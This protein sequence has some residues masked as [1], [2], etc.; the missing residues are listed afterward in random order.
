MTRTCVT[1]VVACLVAAGLVPLAF[2][3]EG[4]WLFNNPPKEILKTRYG[5]D[6]TDSWLEHV[7][8]S[9]VRFNSGGSG[10]FVSADG[11]V[12]TNHHV[13]LETLQKLSTK[14]KNY[15]K[16]GF[17]A[18]T[19]ADEA[20]AVDLEL[21]VLME[22]VDVTERVKAEV[23]PGMSPEEAFKARR[24][25]T[26]I[27]EK[28]SLDKT[29]L[30]SNVISLYQGGRY[31]LYRFK[32]YTDVRLVFAPEQQIAFFGGDPDNFEYPRYNLDVCLFRVY[33][34]DQ[35]LKP[36]HF[37][38]WSKAGA[39]DGELVFVAGHPGRTERLDTMAE[40]EFLRDTGY[41]FTMRRLHRREVMLSVWSARS[42]ENARRAKDELFSIQNARKRYDGALAGLLD[43]VLMDQKREAEKTFRQEIAK[44]EELKE[45]MKA[46]DK[47]AAVQQVRAKHMLEHTALEG[48]AGFGTILFSIARTLVRA[49]A[50]RPK[51][52]HERLEEFT[53]SEKASME[54]RLFSKRPIHDD[55]EQAK[56]ADSL[57]WL[58]EL[59][60]YDHPSVKKAL[61]GKS[62]RA[63]ASELIR[64]TK[65]KDVELRRSLY[66]GGT[67]AIEASDD[68]LIK[69][70]RDVD[71]ESRALRK[72][73]DE[74][75]KELKQQAYDQIA[76]AKFA[77]EGT[78]TYPDATF[79]LRLAFGVCKGYEEDGRQIPCATTYAGLY[80]RAA[81]QKYTPPFDLP[82]RWL[83]RKKDL[84]LAAPFNFVC[85]NDIIGGNSGSPVVNRD[86]EVVGLIFDG[87]IQ[88]LVLDFVFT[89]VQ[90]RALAVHSRGIV[91][92]LRKVCDA[93]HI[94]Q[95]LTGEK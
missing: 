95:E 83:D 59:L 47:I 91:E 41:P 36:E 51:V 13:G 53:E 70:A 64:G 84:D 3:D 26:S 61:A 76:K 2:A 69:L 45:A 58:A 48:G 57:T 88:S 79:T 60:G 54:L 9:A 10:S 34:K 15:V 40:L 20:K 6:A 16:E 68:P 11:L 39:K 31:H 80:D 73:F 1:A 27:I 14:D 5:F 32:R 43:P 28:E 42:L 72:I 92:A 22:I 52:N 65:L 49:A 8:K 93:S 35:P 17:L 78:S 25:I 94:A 46:F 74:Q 89:E 18:R 86:A 55:L 62:P 38:K 37:L 66:D 77:I 56:L 87:N 19:R 30:R 75:V 21:N 12:M 24:A 81:E 85:T 90:S 63:R 33:E 4:M 71:P 7:Q 82:Q 67:K 44:R 23:K 50:E 29:G